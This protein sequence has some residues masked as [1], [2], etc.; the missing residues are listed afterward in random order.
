MPPPCH[1][2][3][4]SNPV[5]IKLADYGMYCDRAIIFV[6]YILET[7]FQVFWDR[8]CCWLSNSWYFFEMVGVIHPMTQQHIAEDLNAHHCQCKN[9]ISHNDRLVTSFNLLFLH[10]RNKSINLTFRNKGV[11]WHWR[12]HGSRNYAIQWWRGIHGKGKIKILLGMLYCSTFTSHTKCEDGNMWKTECRS[13]VVNTGPV[14]KS[15]QPLTLPGTS[16]FHLFFPNLSF[17][18]ICKL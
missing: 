2:A 9:F 1:D 14:F 5:H 8:V 13:I 10:Y 15:Q 7:W 11:W 4:E 6:S 17:I 3:S 12:F 16:D 18:I